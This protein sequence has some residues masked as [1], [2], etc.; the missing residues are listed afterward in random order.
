MNANNTEIGIL[1]SLAQLYILKNMRKYSRQKMALC[2]SYYSILTN[3]GLFLGTIIRGIIAT[4][5]FSFWLIT[6]L[7]F[8]LGLSAILRFFSAYFFLPKFDE[9]RKDVQAFR[10]EI[11]AEEKIKKMISPKNLLNHIQFKF[12]P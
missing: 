8:V 7:V 2:V 4:F 10:L 9:V 12:K 6:P 1:K 11:E 3:L 5:N